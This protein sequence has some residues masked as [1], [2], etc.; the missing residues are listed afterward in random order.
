MD[1]IKTNLSLILFALMSCSK[2]TELV[3]F[4]AEGRDL[5]FGRILTERL[6]ISFLVWVQQEQ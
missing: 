6:L 1:H 2:E 4:S 3:S 5:R